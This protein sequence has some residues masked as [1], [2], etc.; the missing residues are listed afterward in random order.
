MDPLDPA[1]PRTRIAAETPWYE[2][3]SRGARD[4]LRHNDKVREAVTGNLPE[5]L[6]G[7]DILTQPTGR[8]V[9]VPV[10]LLEHSRFRLREAQTRTGAGQGQGEPGDVLRPAQQHGEDAGEG[11]GGTGEGELT[12]VL[13]LKVDDILDWLWEELK[14]PDLKPRTSANMQDD[15][16]VREGWDKRGPRARLDRRRTVKEAVKR[17]AIQY[18]EDRKEI[19]FTNDDLRFRQLVRRQRPAVNAVVMFGLD[20]S[21]SMGEAERK[22]A[23]T[24][25]FFA[26][27][28]LRRQYANVEPVFLAHS[29][30][31]WEFPE[32]QFFQVSG[33]GGT[34]SSSLF[35][36][37]IE[38]LNARFDPSR[39]NAYLF[40]ASDGENASEDQEPAAAAMERLAGRLNYAGYAEIGVTGSRLRQ[41]PLGALFTDLQGRGFPAAMATI[42]RQDDVWRAI[43]TFFSEQAEATA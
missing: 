13:E 4:W 22:L 19:P 7:S 42:A 41:T 18:R 32:D 9:L 15:E 27:H 12:F 1:A 20:V 24:F 28:G 38:T 17:R 35:S 36:L 23:K 39:Y 26:L 30:E 10:K 34:V 3:F 21:G 11:Q 29:V 16:L 14:L 40:Y 25:F 5:L 2:L 33:S 37:A 8:T 31:A 6:S 43:R